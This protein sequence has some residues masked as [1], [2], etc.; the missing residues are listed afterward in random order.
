MIARIGCGFWSAFT[1]AKVQRRAFGGTAHGGRSAGCLCVLITPTP[2]SFVNNVARETPC[3]VGLALLAAG[4][5]A[6]TR[7]EDCT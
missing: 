7:F 6:L 1:E 4:M 5:P 3:G 2:N